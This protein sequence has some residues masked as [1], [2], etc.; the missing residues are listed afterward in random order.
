MKKLTARTLVKHY[1]GVEHLSQK[2]IDTAVS[3]ARG[4]RWVLGFHPISAE[5]DRT[6]VAVREPDPFVPALSLTFAASCPPFN[7][8]AKVQR[9]MLER[10]AG[11][12]LTYSDF[13]HRLA[14]RGLMI[15]KASDETVE[16][17][18]TNPELA[19]FVNESRYEVQLRG[20][21]ATTLAQA[22]LGMAL[23]PF[24]ISPERR[25]E[26]AQVYEDLD[27]DALDLLVG[28]KW[29]RLRSGWMMKEVV[30]AER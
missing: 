9:E 30:G 5:P 10:I 7:K 15:A 29:V 2:R 23:R 28:K 14:K 25:Q 19:R 6:V 27:I 22:A 13:G 4:E 20:R 1:I 24:S 21:L 3:I 16:L 17:I 11:C 8:V 12:P 26:A 18:G